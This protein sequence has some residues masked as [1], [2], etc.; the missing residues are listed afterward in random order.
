METCGDVH[1]VIAT[2]NRKAIVATT[3]CEYKRQ[4]QIQMIG[5]DSDLDSGDH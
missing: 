5:S 1:I 3:V 2:E 4:I